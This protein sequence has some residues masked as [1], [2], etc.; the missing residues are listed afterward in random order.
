MEEFLNLGFGLLKLGTIARNS[1]IPCK[2]CLSGT[3]SELAPKHHLGVAL[4]AASLANL[5]QA[6]NAQIAR[7]LLA[8][9]RLRFSQFQFVGYEAPDSYLMPEVP[10]KLNGAAA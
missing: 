2:I 1:H 5:R 10:V 3:I 7:L 8:G 4:P 9:C 6:R